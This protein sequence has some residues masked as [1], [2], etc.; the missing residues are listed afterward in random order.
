MPG[1]SSYIN[2]EAELESGG[3]E[4]QKTP[5]RSV[6]VAGGNLNDTGLRAMLRLS[7]QAER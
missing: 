1:R 6:S 2:N 4:K 5:F 3:W 7:R